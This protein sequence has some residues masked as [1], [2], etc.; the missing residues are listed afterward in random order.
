[1]FYRAIKLDNHLLNFQDFRVH[2][3]NIC[4]PQEPPKDNHDMTSDATLSLQ[5]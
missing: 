4:V 1:M 2:N 5:T 3:T